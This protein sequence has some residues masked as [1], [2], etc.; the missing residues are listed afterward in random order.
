[1]ILPD[2]S[3]SSTVLTHTA[4]LLGSKKDDKELSVLKIV[5]ILSS[6]LSVHHYHHCYNHCHP[7]LIRRG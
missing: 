1:M 7:L 3:S 4:S 2:A 5:H 6:S